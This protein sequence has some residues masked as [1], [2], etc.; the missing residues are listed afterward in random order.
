M[1]HLNKGAG[2]VILISTS[3]Y[4]T[5]HNGTTISHTHGCECSGSAQF[6]HRTSEKTLNK[7]CWVLSGPGMA[8]LNSPGIP[9]LARFTQL[10]CQPSSYLKRSCR[11]SNPRYV[12]KDANSLHIELVSAHQFSG[13]TVC[14]INSEENQD[15]SL[16]FRGP[17]ACFT[18]QPMVW[19]ARHVQKT[20][21]DFP[22]E[23]LFT[24][25]STYN[26]LLDVNVQ[27]PQETSAL[28]APQPGELCL[29]T[30]TLALNIPSKA[31]CGWSGKLFVT[32]ES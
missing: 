19:W 4:S 20:R 9:P 25:H 22:H 27:P 8:H 28:T 30:T 13:Y 10:I 29:E 12:V 16:R 17:A 31:L 5:L 26:S 15:T 11:A 24:I 23:H 18:T 6:T 32:H 7:R 3:P 2:N 1:D 21:M 14:L